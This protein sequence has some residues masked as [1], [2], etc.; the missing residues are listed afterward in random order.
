[1]TQMLEWPDKHF[2]V[3]IIKVFQQA[4]VNTLETN[5]KTQSFTEEIQSLNKETEE[6]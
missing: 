3:A 6:I 2:K 1:M 4:I 5:E